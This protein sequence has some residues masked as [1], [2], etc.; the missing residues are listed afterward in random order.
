M[1]E[2]W[3]KLKVG[4]RVRVVRMP[5][6]VDEPG[7]TFHRDTRKLYKRLIARGYTQRI[8]KI[9]PRGVPWIECRFRLPDGRWEY[10]S[11]ALNDDLWVLVKRK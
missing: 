3:R 6:G 4:D 1:N 10:H 7:Y 11:L 2:E 9:D 8:S 5:S